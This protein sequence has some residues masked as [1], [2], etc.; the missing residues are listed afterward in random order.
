MTK[1]INPIRYLSV[2]ETASL[3][4]LDPQ[5]IYL[6][7]KAGEVPAVNFASRWLIPSDWVTGLATNQRRAAPH[8]PAQVVRQGPDMES[9][10]KRV[11]AV[12]EQLQAISKALAELSQAW[13]TTEQ[14][15][16][17]P[18]HKAASA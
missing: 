3:L 10:G 11:L 1:P 12:Q 5:T 9:I 4:G 13:A 7:I 6:K 8:G 15:Q 16:V 18:E 17:E 2:K 14:S